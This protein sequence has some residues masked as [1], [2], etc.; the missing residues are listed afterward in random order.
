MEVI[1][2]CWPFSGQLC[3]SALED[4]LQETRSAD[5]NQ[6]LVLISVIRCQH[7][8]MLG[9]SNA[10]RLECLRPLLAMAQVMQP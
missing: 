10:H 8:F 7:I 3:C 1:R 5:G 2:M 4:Q 6:L 9:K